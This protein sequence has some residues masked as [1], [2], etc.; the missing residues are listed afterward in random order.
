MADRTSMSR[1]NQVRAS[2][3]RIFRGRSSRSAVLTAMVGILTVFPILSGCG[4]EKGR[5]EAIGGEAPRRIAGAGPLIE[6]GD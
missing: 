5:D 4:E 3:G 1:K 6:P 2:A